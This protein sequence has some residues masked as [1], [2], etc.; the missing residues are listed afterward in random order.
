M[1]PDDFKSLPTALQV[2]IL[3]RI[4]FRT[5][6]DFSAALEA[7]EK[8]EPARRP[9][10]DMKLPAGKGQFRWAS[11]CDL[12]G[13][14]YWHKRFS[15]SEG[16]WAEKDRSKAEKLQYWLS[17]RAE[18]PDAVWAGIRGDDEV[19]AQRPNGRPQMHPWSGPGPQA[20]ADHKPAESYSDSDYG[21]K[22]GD[23]LPF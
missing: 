10:Y 12:E 11:E 15:E 21:T 6:P 1:T 9:K 18:Q 4:L 3:A 2:R 13:L 8:P 20:T 17:W 7:E 22:E 19:T 23:D 5:L 14:S 16:E